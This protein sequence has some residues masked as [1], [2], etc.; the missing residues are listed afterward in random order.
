MEFTKTEIKTLERLL[1]NRGLTPRAIALKGLSNAFLNLRGLL[2]LV[3]FVALPVL[4][5]HEP[6]SGLYYFLLGVLATGVAM[7][8]LFILSTSGVWMTTRKIIDWEKVDKTLGRGKI[9]GLKSYAK[10]L[11]LTLNLTAHRL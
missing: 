10:A 11:A 9:E 8:I 2:T 7:R 5:A 4:I 3:M 6:G 1:G